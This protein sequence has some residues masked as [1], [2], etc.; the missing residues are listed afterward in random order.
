MVLFIENFVVKLFSSR[1]IRKPSTEIIRAIVFRYHGIVR[2]WILVGG[3]LYEI[4]NPAIMLP[5]ARRLMGLIRSGLFS[6]IVIKGGKR[7]FV[8]VTK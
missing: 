6:L 8:M 1:A 7:G 4:M 3:I 5:N 2:I